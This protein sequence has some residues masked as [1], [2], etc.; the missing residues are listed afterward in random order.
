M[1]PVNEA[2]SESK[3]GGCVPTAWKRDEQEGGH[4]RNVPRCE[5]YN[6]GPEPDGT[7][8][9]KWIPRSDR[10]KFGQG[11]DRPGR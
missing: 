2:L 3:Q 8:E 11:A 9:G 6:L 1:A 10:A 5:P 4:F 7:G